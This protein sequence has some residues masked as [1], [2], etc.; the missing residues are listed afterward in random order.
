MNE[1]M[2]LSVKL[3]VDLTKQDYDELDNLLLCLDE[4][5]EE[6][7]TLE[8]RLLDIMDEDGARCLE[9]LKII[10]KKLAKYFG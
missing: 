10:R 7:G 3:S 8:D 5:N 2:E 4:Q 6:D 9:N 1:K